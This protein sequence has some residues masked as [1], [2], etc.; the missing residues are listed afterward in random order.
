M[1]KEK[2]VATLA[3]YLFPPNYPDIRSYRYYYS[4]IYKDKYYN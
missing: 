1:A 3:S 2:A 4:R